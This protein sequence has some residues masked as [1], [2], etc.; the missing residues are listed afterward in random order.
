MGEEGKAIIE[1]GNIMNNKHCKDCGRKHTF[2]PTLKER[3]MTWNE[4]KSIFIDAKGGR[5]VTCYLEHNKIEVIKL[6]ERLAA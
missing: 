6:I 5:C 4:A 1:S 2:I 3:G